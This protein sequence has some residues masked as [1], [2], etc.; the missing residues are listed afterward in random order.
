[1]RILTHSFF[2]F[3]HVKLAV[4]VYAGYL[5]AVCRGFNT[6]ALLVLVYR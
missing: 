2:V 5:G 6:N 3:A 1:M 4:L